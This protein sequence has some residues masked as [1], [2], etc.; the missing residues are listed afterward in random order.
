MKYILSVLIVFF[1]S[2]TAVQ[3]TVETPSGTDANQERLKSSIVEQANQMQQEL[4]NGNLEGFI[5]YV[6]P[7]IV[8]MMGGLDNLKATIGPGLPEMLKTVK[9]TTFGSVSEVIEDNGRLVAFMPVEM[10][11]AFPEGK[12]IQMTYRIACSSD[13][14]VSWTFLDGQGRKDQEDFF[15]QKFPVLTTTFPFPNCYNQRVQ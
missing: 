14:G 15:R 10:L 2:C 4:M 12:M 7:D 3:S 9:K 6:H 1:V 5:K 8:T 11:Y 13:N